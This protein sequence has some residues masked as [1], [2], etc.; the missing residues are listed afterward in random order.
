MVRAV[1][2]T[3]LS[4]FAPQHGGAIAGIDMTSLSL[5]E[6][7]FVIVTEIVQWRTGVDI[8]QT[9]LSNTRRIAANVNKLLK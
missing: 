4:A 5:Y 1:K 2:S 9:E 6:D 8:K 7:V 3:E